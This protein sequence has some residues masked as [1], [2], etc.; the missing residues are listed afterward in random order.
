MSRYGTGPLTELTTPSTTPIENVNFSDICLTTSEARLLLEQRTKAF[1]KE[2]L[3]GAMHEQ[4]A[5]QREAAQYC[6]TFARFRTPEATKAIRSAL[7]SAGLRP[8]EIAVMGS[9]CPSD[10]EE[11]KALV[12]SLS[13]FTY[14]EVKKMIMD[15]EQYKQY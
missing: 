4:P 11:A 9:L 3:S 10:V 8:G 12:P 1:K 2:T 7:E 5:L 15:I 6:E 14:G 13:R